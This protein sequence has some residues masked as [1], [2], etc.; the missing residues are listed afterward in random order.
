[1]D[2]IREDEGICLAAIINTVLDTGRM[3]ILSL[4]CSHYKNSHRPRYRKVVEAYTL[5]PLKKKPQ[6]WIQGGCGSL[7]CRHYKN[8]PQSWIQEGCG[9]LSLQPL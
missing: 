4:S 3:W 2:Q 8:K 7:P 1:M 6:S 9:S 5:Q